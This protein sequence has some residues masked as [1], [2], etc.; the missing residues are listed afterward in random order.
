MYKIGRG[1]CIAELEIIII[2]TF[3]LSFLTTYK[4]NLAHATDQMYGTNCAID[5]SICIPQAR[6]QRRRSTFALCTTVV[7]PVDR[8]MVFPDSDLDINVS[9]SPKDLSLE[10]E[11]ELF[12]FP[13]QSDGIS[14]PI[15]DKP[16]SDISSLLLEPEFHGFSP[17]AERPIRVLENSNPNI[18]EETLSHIKENSS[19]EFIEIPIHP[20]S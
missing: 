16:S 3:I 11:L 12:G 4:G 10:S 2:H 20:L 17:Q 14:D 6:A 15:S 19:E 13:S 7:S 5:N 1:K 18:F 9:E 8:S